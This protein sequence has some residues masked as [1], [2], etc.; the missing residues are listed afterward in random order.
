MLHYLSNH[1]ILVWEQDVSQAVLRRSE[2]PIVIFNHLAVG[3]M[4]R[5]EYERLLESSSAKD[6]WAI[7]AVLG[8]PRVTLGSA[9]R[10]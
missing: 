2:A 10:T 7:L 8:F 6:I 4:Q 5:P 9:L 3:S 1:I